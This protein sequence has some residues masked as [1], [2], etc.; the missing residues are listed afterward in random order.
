MSRPTNTNHEFVWTSPHV[1]ITKNDSSHIICWNKKKVLNANWWLSWW[2]KT[3]SDNALGRILADLT[4]CR[5]ANRGAAESRG[6]QDGGAGWG[7][8][9]SG[10]FNPCLWYNVTW[11]TSDRTSSVS[12]G[13]ETWN[14]GLYKH[15]HTAK[16]SETRICAAEMAVRYAALSACRKVRMPSV[17]TEKYMCVIVIR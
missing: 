1:S 6:S 16:L 2:V 8:W 17:R 7:I 10:W 13:I 15:P 9:R 14:E 11:R 3:N 12:N 4:T 5:I